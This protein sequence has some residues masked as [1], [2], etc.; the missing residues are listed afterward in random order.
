VRVFDDRRTS[1]TFVCEAP[2]LIEQRLFALGRAIESELP[3]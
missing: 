2:I 1:L 3:D